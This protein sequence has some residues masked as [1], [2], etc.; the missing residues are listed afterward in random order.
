MD[1]SDTYYNAW[2]T[3]FLVKQIWWS[4]TS[5]KWEPTA[6]PPTLE[7]RFQIFSSHDYYLLLFSRQV[8]SKCLRPHGLQ[9]TR[10]PCPSPSPRVC[11]NSCP[12]NWWCHPTISCSVALFSFCRQSCPASGSFPV[13]QLFIS[14]TGASA[15]ASFLPKSIQ[16]WYTL[17]L[18]G[19]ISLL[20][21]GLSRGFSSTIVWKH[22]FF[23]ILPSLLFISH[24]C[25]WV[26]DHYIQPKLPSPNGTNTFQKTKQYK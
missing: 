24:I 11:P 16:G 22:Q 4:S 7:I 18:S 3:E 25:T 23:G 14:S 20:S 2:L 19:L 12:F 1:A 8:V 13:S 26:L 17:R 6:T 10:L 15:S 9:H 5:C 21:K